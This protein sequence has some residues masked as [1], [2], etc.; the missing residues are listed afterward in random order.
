MFVRRYSGH[1]EKADQV[2]CAERQVTDKSNRTDT[3]TLSSL[4][5]PNKSLGESSVYTPFKGTSPPARRTV[6]SSIFQIR[7]T[8]GFLLK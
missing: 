4:M 2:Q 8:V 3:N 6:D 7:S 5:T 1:I